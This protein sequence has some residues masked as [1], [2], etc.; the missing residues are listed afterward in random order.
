MSAA[1]SPRKVK[2]SFEKEGAVLCVSDIL[3]LRAVGDAIKRTPKYGQIAASVR[4]IGL[5]E[6]LAVARQKQGKYLLLDG[7]LRLEVLREL[8]AET[9]Q[10]LIS[11]DDEAFTYNRRI[12]R[13]AIIQEHRMILKAIERGVPEERIAKA[14]NIEVNT[15]RA[16][17]QL[18]N[19]ICSEAADL[20]KDKHVAI[21]T[22]S[23]LR[24]MSPL[25]QIE[26]AELM[27]AMNQFTSTYAN[28]L[29]AATGRDQLVRPDQPKN[30]KGITSELMVLMERESA[31]LEREF[32][33]ATQSYGTDH[34]DM[35][36]V[37]GYLTKLL[38]NARVVR[39]LAKHH[40]DLLSEF[41]QITDMQ[42]DV[43]ESA[44]R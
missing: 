23:I 21:S 38:G 15:L 19:G 11:T 40:Q 36:L 4:E 37:K 12:N 41:H 26:A 31:N 10:C 13:I 6:P 7:H 1:P 30:L 5:V 17:K 34:L 18:L 14:L 2:S 8:G 39:H 33:L 28:S 44:A 16:R 35:V 24:K 3:P 43:A 9:V 29:L 22:F 25:R 27:V 42:M 32:K 20:L